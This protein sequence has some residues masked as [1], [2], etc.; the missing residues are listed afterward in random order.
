[1]DGAEEEAEDKDRKKDGQEKWKADRE[2]T[3]GAR[4]VED[5]VIGGQTAGPT[6]FL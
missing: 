3:D 4:L 1:M 2:G 6:Y 5:G